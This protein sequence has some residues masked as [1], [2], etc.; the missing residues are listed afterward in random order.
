MQQENVLVEERK[1]EKVLVVDDSATIRELLRLILEGLGFENV[2]LAE[3]GYHS[4]EIFQKEKPDITF[5]DMNLPNMSGLETLKVMLAINPSSKIILT[6]AFPKTDKDVRNA[7]AQGAAYYLEKPLDRR[8]ITEIV[9]RI[10]K[11]GEKS[12]EKEIMMSYIAKV[13]KVQSQITDNPS[14]LVFEFDSSHNFNDFSFSI[15][16]RKGISIKGLQFY[17]GKFV[18]TVEILPPHMVL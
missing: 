15:S 14:Y 17:K 13:E 5:L 18:V 1:K 4:L 16:K 12:R 2:Y 9:E 10:E 11:E 8:K 7:I 3:D 6:T